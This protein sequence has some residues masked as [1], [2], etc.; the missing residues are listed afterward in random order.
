MERAVS[1]R[2]LE[3]NVAVQVNAPRADLAREM[4]PGGTGL[5]SMCYEH[6]GI[7]AFALMLNAVIVIAH[8]SGGAVLD[9]VRH[10]R[11]GLPT[12][13]VDGF[14]DAAVTVLGMLQRQRAT[15]WPRAHR[16][17]CD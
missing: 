5:H 6:F 11:N 7:S 8:C 12:D 9:I 3:E 4:Q 14:V 15:R 17:V 1:E 13:D 16:H 10:G 2:K